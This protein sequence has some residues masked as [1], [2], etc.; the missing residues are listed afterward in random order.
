[1]IPELNGDTGNCVDDRQLHGMAFMAGLAQLTT[2]RGSLIAQTAVAFWSMRRGAGRIT[3]LGLGHHPFHWAWLLNLHNQ[4]R[5]LQG[6][7]N[8][9]TA[10]DLEPFPA[11]VR[12]TTHV[13]SAQR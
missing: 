10:N 11:H 3:R 7:S 8:Q 12:D 5:P 13:L 4:S 2:E 9:K 1:M 6:N